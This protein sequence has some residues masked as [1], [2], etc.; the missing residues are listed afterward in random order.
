MKKGKVF[1][2]LTAQFKNENHILEE[3]LKHYVKWG[4]QHFYLL[5]D[6]STDNFMK[7]PFLLFLVNK[8]MITLINLPKYTDQRQ[9][10]TNYVLPIAKNRTKWLIVCDLDEF[11][12]SPNYKTISE[13]LVKYKNYNS[14]TYFRKFFNSKL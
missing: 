11:I 3:W 14:Y 13:A 4:V 8:N 2:S 1:L 5:N 10:Y 12:Y 6:N 9:N 7:N